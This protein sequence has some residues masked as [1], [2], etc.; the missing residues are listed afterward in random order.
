M[1]FQILDSAY[2]A[3][4]RVCDELCKSVLFDS[5][6]SDAD[7]TVVAAIFVIVVTFVFFDSALTVIA[8]F[9]SIDD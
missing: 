2:A 6:G 7:G 1:K 4:G 3:G 9:E 5:D 8:G